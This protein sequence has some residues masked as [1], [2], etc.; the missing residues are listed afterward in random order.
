VSAMKLNA[1]CGGK[2]A[3]SKIDDSALAPSHKAELLVA[4]ESQDCA[5]V[6]RLLLPA[7]I[8]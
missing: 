4:D 5:I 6:L 7:C 1:S 2:V 8:T 3:F